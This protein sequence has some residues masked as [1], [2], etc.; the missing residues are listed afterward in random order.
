MGLLTRKRRR[1]EYQ[2]L[3]D[4][5]CL[6]AVA[7]VNH[8]GVLHVVGNAD[9]LVNVE[10]TGTDTF[11]VSDDG[12]PLGSFASVNRIWVSLDRHNADSNTVNVN[13]HSEVIDGVFAALGGGENEFNVQGEQAIGRVD[14]HGGHGVDTVNVNVETTGIVYARLH[15]GSDVI[16]V[17]ENANRIRLRGGGGDDVL[18]IGPL[19]NVNFVGAIMES[20]SNEV[21]VA[22]HVAQSL[23]VSGGHQNDIVRLAEGAST[24]Y[25]QVNLGHGKNVVNVA[26]EVTNNF[27]Y[28]GGDHADT[29]RLTA[30]SSVRTVAVDLG[31]SQNFPNELFLNG[32]VRNLFVSA[33]HG[34][35]S[36]VFSETA[37]THYSSLV[38]G[39]GD[40]RVVTNGTHTDNLYFRGFHGHDTFLIGAN[41][42]IN[43]SVRAVL[44]SGDNH[45]QHDGLIEGN[46]LVLSKNP[47]DVFSVN[48]FVDGFTRLFPGGQR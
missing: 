26:G 13:L 23:Y 43:G 25:L 3:E 38:L 4:R 19:A 21:N 9:G 14:Y 31:H 8:L 32:T 6:T 17:S 22:G 5:L 42:E 37:T 20:G 30:E 34:V 40:N 18:S 35:D 16:N 11:D 15:G 46:L 28:R 12:V 7:N 10:A 1:L 45:F 2:N 36:I 33:G 48:G 47:N 41:A 44:G 29:I 39:N 27:Y 24:R